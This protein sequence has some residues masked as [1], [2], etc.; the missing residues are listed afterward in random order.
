MST[1]EDCGA[2]APLIETGEFK[3]QPG[4]LDYCTYCSRDLCAECLKKECDEHPEEGASH[5]VVSDD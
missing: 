2:Q 3:G 5:E 1:C 4:L